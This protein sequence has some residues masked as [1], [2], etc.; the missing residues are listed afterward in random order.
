MLK[1]RG[2]AFKLI[3]AICVSGGLIFI[4]I[5]SFNYRFSRTMIEKNVEDSARNLVQSKVNKI[6][7][8]LLSVN[9]VPESMACFLEKG[10][11]DQEELLHLLHAVVKNNSEI[12][13]A[14]IAFEPYAF[15][16]RSL[17]FAPYFCKNSGK[18]EFTYLGGEKYPYFYLDWYQIPKE[19]NHPCWSEPYFDEGGGNILMATYSVPFY[20]VVGGK[21]QFKGIVTADIS[22]G[23]L[24]DVVSSIK[25]LQT[26][27]GFLISKNGTVVTHPLKDLIMN[28][29][30]FGVAE[31]RGDTH[32][33]EIGRKMIR[34]ESGFVS[35]KSIASEKECWMYYTPIP[36]SSWSLAV[37]FPQDEFMADITRLNKIVIILAVGG[38]LLLS[39]VVAFISRSI[40][41]PLRAMARAIRDIGKG[42]LDIELPEAKTGDEVGKLTEAFQY[43]KT[44]LKEYIEQ[45]TET[46]ASQERIESELKIARD[47][48]MNMLPKKFPPFPERP[49]FDIYAMIEPA[50]EV[51]GDFYDFF[52][53]DDEHLC[54]A[55]GDVSGKGIPASLFMAITKTLI[56]AKT[57]WDADPGR[58]VTKVN[59]DLS[60]G[61]DACMFVTIFCGM[62]NTKTGEV[63]YTNAGHN[64][65]FLLQQ[66]R[67]VTSIEGGRNVVAGVLDS[68]VYETERLVLQPGDALFM[69][70]DGVTEA[71]DERQE[72]FSEE[73]L[74][75]GIIG[76]Q[77]RSAQEMINGIKEQVISFAHGLPQSDDITMMIIQFNGN[78]NRNEEGKS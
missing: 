61:N 27:Y 24:Q 16:K 76:L 30:I 60:Q 63:F 77:G 20:R 71:M 42:N 13:G 1:N 78:Q 23:W 18:I 22:L 29:T 40:T 25:V 38:L 39:L 4:L 48:Q 50:R 54:F 33:R 9:K 14:T 51:G 66:G 35:F 6:E 41:D 2:I 43:M 17:Y 75:S 67:G 56:K 44:S 53:I 36:S 64:P 31:V 72:L 37:L 74:R 7:T 3:L 10:S 8:I 57:S 69:Y 11:C 21:R 49:E 59:N 68:S 32:L 5:F 46:T 55:I 52:F 73:R 62:L 34:G 70:T 58:I 28:E 12:Y 19:L 47:I 26:G 15:D 45:L 65:P